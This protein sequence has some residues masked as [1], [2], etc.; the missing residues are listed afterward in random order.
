[1]NLL[2]AEMTART[3]KDPA[4]RYKELTALHGAPAYRR[5]EAPATS[6]SKRLCWL[7][8]LRSTLRFRS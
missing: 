6:A 4:E 5:S 1:M 3:G 7:L 8:Y 2:A